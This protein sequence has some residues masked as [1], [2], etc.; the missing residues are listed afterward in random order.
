MPGKLASASGPKRKAQE[1]QPPPPEEVRPLNRYSTWL[2]CLHSPKKLS[3]V[4][5]STSDP[6]TIVLMLD[7]PEVGVISRACEALLKHVESCK[8]V[9]DS[10]SATDYVMLCPTAEQN[11]LEIV[12]LGGT[13]RMI[14]LLSSSEKV[15][16][17]HAV[18]C[19]AAMAATG[20]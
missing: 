14:H 7:S 16:R 10:V 15:A 19:L 4:E 9:F 11:I 20:K 1:K 3:K 8:Y 5:I 13:P 12:E 6:R 18:L 17:C 2:E